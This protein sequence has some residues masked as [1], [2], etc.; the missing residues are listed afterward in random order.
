MPSVGMKLKKVFLR[1][2]VTGFKRC[3]LK[4][5]TLVLRNVWEGESFNFLWP[6]KD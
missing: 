4:E 6:R 3:L 1:T 2:K 5:S